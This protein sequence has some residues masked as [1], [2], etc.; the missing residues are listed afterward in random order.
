MN[1]RQDKHDTGLGVSFIISTVIHLAVFLL[2]MWW[3][4]LFPPTMAVQETYYVDVVNLPVADPRAGSPTQKGND[5]EAPPPPP[6]PEAP[7]SMPSPPQPN[8]RG[9]AATAQKAEKRETP[10]DAAFAERMAKLENKAASQHEEATLEQLR[11]KLKATSSGRAGMPAGSGSETG[12]DYTAYV[13]SRLKDALNQTNDYGS[14]NPMV[15]VH[16]YIGTDGKVIR[17]KSESSG[18]KRFELAVQRAIEK[19][20]DKLVPPPNHKVFEGKF[21]FRPKEVSRSKP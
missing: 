1:A 11:K 21:R 20:G 15:Y 7:L 19:A 16:L 8:A 2:Q 13:Q 3:G 5:A 4:Q 12:S 9:R 10:S 17:Q 14:N 6:A 18:D